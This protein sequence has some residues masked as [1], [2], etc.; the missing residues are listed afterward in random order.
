MTRIDPRTGEEYQ[1]PFVSGNSLKHQIR[2]GA[3]RHALAAMAVPD[4]VLPRPVVQL[5]FSGG[6][7]QSG[8]NSVNVARARRVARLFPALS[9]CGYAAGNWMERSKMR[10]GLLELVCRENGWLLPPSLRGHPCAGLSAYDFRGEEF[11]TR[12]SPL[13]QPQASRYL[14][15]DER[16]ALDREKG[17]QLQRRAK[18]KKPKKSADSLQM[19]YDFETL[20]SGAVL[21]GEVSFDDLTPMEI[22]ALRSGLSFACQGKHDENT[23]LYDF[24]AKSNV[25]FGRAAVGFDG[26]ITRVLAPVETPTGDLLPVPRDRLD[27]ADD[28]GYAAHLRE[29][30]DEILALLAEVA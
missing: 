3:V 22:E 8:G 14:P 9:L 6:N 20:R 10:C 16:A 5:L 11:G 29:H 4:G 12:H 1:V 13:R 27:G 7:L 26:A 2:A 23:Y 24:G 21:Y 30:R 19:I 17:S 28:A 25:G 18:K 15:G